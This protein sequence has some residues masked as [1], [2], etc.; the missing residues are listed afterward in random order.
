MLS[1]AGAGWAGALAAPAHG[2]GAGRNAGFGA[3][4]LFAGLILGFLPVEQGFLALFRLGLC[5]LGSLGGGVL[6]VTVK[7]PAGACGRGN[8]T[9]SAE[10]ESEANNQKKSLHSDH[11]GHLN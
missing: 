5:R 9:E 4:G 11:N 10:S 7:G 6:V 2:L 1:S 8:W 3:R